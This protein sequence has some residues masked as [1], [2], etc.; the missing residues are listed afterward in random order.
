MSTADTKALIE[1]AVNRLGDEVPSLRQLKLVVRLELRARG[2][3][4]PVWRVEIPGPEIAK[5]A[6]TD[7]RVEV[8]IAR[9]HFNELAQD[10]LLKHWVDAYRQGHVR[11]S[12][13]QAVVK[14]IGSVIERHLARGRATSR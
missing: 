5:Q 2:D 4:V 12:G 9:S 13:E 6:A 8:S 3:N 1:R 11:V 14:L 7:A 10:G